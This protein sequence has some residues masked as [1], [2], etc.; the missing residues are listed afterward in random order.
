MLLLTQRPCGS[1]HFSWTNLYHA[2]RGKPPTV[3]N[4]QF[5][6][7]S[8]K[9]RIVGVIAIFRQLLFR[10]PEARPLEPRSNIENPYNCVFRKLG[11]LRLQSPN[12]GPRLLRKFHKVF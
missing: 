11:G 6:Q 9:R 10:P 3:V 8:P 2:T 7:L 4:R 5:H 1:L 12:L